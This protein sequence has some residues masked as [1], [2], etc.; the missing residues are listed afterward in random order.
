[1]KITNIYPLIV[2]G[3][4]F[5][6]YIFVVA[7]TD[8]GVTGFGDATLDGME[9]EVSAAIKSFSEKLIGKNVEKD[10]LS[11]GNP[12]GGLITSTAASGIDI[13]MWDLKGK[14]FGLPVYKL[15]G[16]TR[17]DKIKVYASFNRF[18]KDRTPEGFGKM[19]EK[20]RDMG[21][22]GMKCHPFDMVNWQTPLREQKKWVDLGCERFIAMREAVGDEYDIGV[23]AHWRFDLATAA[24][25]ADRLRPYRPFWLET[26]LPEKNVK[27]IAEFRKNCGLVL[28]GG[29]MKTGAQDFLPLLEN[30]CFDVYMPDVRYCGGITGIMETIHVVESYDRMISPHNMCTAISC[31]AS[32]HVSAAVRN[33]YHME[34]HPDEADWI[35]EL[36][37]FNFRPE[38]GYFDIPDR[39]GLGVDLNLEVAKKHPY[40]KAIPV[41]AN[42]LGA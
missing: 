28:A 4:K 10:N 27:D 1:M 33:F 12:A 41:R 9:F 16:G 13:A 19:A 23:D 15:L 31:A 34:F 20:L 26:P 3:S 17:R 11:V 39:P 24:Y 25:V 8:E 37:D 32:V 6:N 35:E 30:Q 5:S 36:T 14:A 40:E 42:M 22:T 2:H 18:I 21:N 29:E 38:Q 7:E